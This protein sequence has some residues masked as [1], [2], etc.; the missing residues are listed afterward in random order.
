MSYSTRLT[1][2][3]LS[4][5]SLFSCGTKTPYIQP[6]TETISETVYASGFVKSVGQY[7]V[8]GKANGILEKIWVAK[9]DLVKKG[10]VLF[11]ISNDVS[12]LTRAMLN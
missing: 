3:S 12:A 10:Q 4:L 5:F 6:N 1:L 7:Q 2:L 8:F 11:S 9:G